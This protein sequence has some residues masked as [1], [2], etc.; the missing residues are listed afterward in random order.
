MPT[1]CSRWSRPSS[2]S[3][4]ASS[5]HGTHQDAQTL[6]SETLPLKA[7]G[8]SP[9]IGAP[10]LASPCNAGNGVCGAGW[11]IRADGM[12]EGSPSP[13]RNQKIAASAAK[14]T[15]GH[16]ISQR[17]LR[18]ASFDGLSFELPFD[19]LG[20]LMTRAPIPKFASY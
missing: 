5:W 18:G 10:L 2:V 16:A 20:S 13:N 19:V 3:N 15:S 8:S 17:E 11:P 7:E 9:G 6:T 14:T 4:G 1:I 12:R